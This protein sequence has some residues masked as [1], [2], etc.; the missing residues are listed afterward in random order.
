M[1]HKVWVWVNTLICW[2][3][4]HDSNVE[5]VA[6]RDKQ[7][8]KSECCELANELDSFVTASKVK[9]F[10]VKQNCLIAV[11]NCEVVLELHAYRLR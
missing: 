5:P 3:Q 8:I 2:K 11:R 1:L 10:A 4:C 7:Q 9:H 6:F